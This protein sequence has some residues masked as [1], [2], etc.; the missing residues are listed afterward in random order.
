MYFIPNF[1]GGNWPYGE[2]S[3]LGYV[4]KNAMKAL[5]IMIELCRE[6]IYIQITTETRAIVR[7]QDK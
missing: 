3:V 2:Y 5:K 7:L 1:I 4:N 6:L